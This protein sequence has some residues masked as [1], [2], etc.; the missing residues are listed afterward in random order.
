MKKY[1]VI[2]ATSNDNQHEQLKLLWNKSEEK[3]LEIA[4]NQFTEAF[5]TCDDFEICIIFSS[6]NPAKAAACFKSILEAKLDPGE[7][8]D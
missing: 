8:D 2:S 5:P 6:R 4:K 1:F 7:V 3:V